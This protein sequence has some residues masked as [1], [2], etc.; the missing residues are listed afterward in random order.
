MLITGHVDVS[1]FSVEI[2]MKLV[3]LQ[4][5]KC[6][7]MS[8][9]TLDFN[10]DVLT[11]HFLMQTFISIVLLGEKNECLIMHSNTQLRL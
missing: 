9:F 8:L 3:P 10:C 1:C 2:S 6:E 4:M 5:I 7:Y 11:N